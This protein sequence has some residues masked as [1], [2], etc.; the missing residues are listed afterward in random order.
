MCAHLCVCVRV[1]VC[2]RAC[3]CMCVC[4]GCC[5]HFPCCIAHYIIPLPL[6][7]PLLHGLQARDNLAAENTDLKRENAELRAQVIRNL[8]YANGC[9]IICIGNICNAFV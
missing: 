1:C 5:E 6:P 7:L 4:V 8:N 3:A 9:L 2:V